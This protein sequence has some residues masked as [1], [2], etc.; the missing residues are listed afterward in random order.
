M[1]FFNM[2][3]SVLHAERVSEDGIRV[4]PIHIAHSLQAMS[5]CFGRAN[6]PPV[7]LSCSPPSVRPSVVR[8]GWLCVSYQPAGDC[9]TPASH[10][11][12]R[13]PPKT[14]VGLSSALTQAG[15]GE[16]LIWGSCAQ[17]KYDACRGRTAIYTCM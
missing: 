7:C 14:L 16:P 10:T 4:T 15:M 5:V 2:P 11:A 9:G 12:P 6:R 8:Q 17:I 13:Q 1:R 3:L